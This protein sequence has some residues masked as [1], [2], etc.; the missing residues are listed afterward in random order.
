[1]TLLLFCI[2][3][4]QAE[5]TTQSGAGE[6]YH[7]RLK[8]PEGRDSIY[9]CSGLH[10]GS[11]G[12]REGLWLVCDR[13]SGPCGNQVFFVDKRRLTKA[14]NGSDIT[15]DESI[16]IV[17]PAEGWDGFI[18]R[19]SMIAA[20][21][22]SDLRKQIENKIKGKGPILDLEDITIG[23]ISAGNRGMQ[24]LVVAEQPH[25][26]VLGL[27]LEEKQPRPV[28]VLT[29]CFTYEEGKA[30]QG[31]DANDGLEGITWSGRAGEFYLVEEGTKPHEP[32]YTLLYFQNPRILKCTLKDGRVIADKRW[33]HELTEKV[34]RLRGHPMQTLNAVTCMDKETLLA[35]DRNGGWVISVNLNSR[36]VRRRFSLYDPKLLNL[37]QRL[38]DFPARRYMPYVSIEGIAGDVDGN[39]WMVDD[40]AAPEAFKESCLIRVANPPW[41]S[42]E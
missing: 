11:L 25:S 20:N 37:R 21:V 27:R 30:A 1:M 2:S 29:N 36:E 33:S 9:Q 15:T 34:R 40:P 10:Y 31:D 24:L 4:C 7:Y 41:F 42:S 14:R 5:P 39:I 18:K 35:V 28:A 19:H 32:T 22:L 3:L 26:V 13:N 17:P 23:R 12:K 8:M 38:S 16:S 6:V